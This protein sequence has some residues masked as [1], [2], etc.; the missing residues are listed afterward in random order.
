VTFETMSEFRTTGDGSFSLGSKTWPGL[1]KLVEECGEVLQVAG[2]LM[3]TAGAVGHWDGAGALDERMALEVCD[4]FAAAR[5]FF[6]LNGFDGNPV[7][8]EREHAKYMQFLKW[9]AKQVPLPEDKVTPVEDI[10]AL[11]LKYMS[12]HEVRIAWNREGDLCHVLK[13]YHGDDK[14]YPVCGLGIMYD[15]HTEAVDAAIAVSRKG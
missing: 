11:R 4:L 10:N 2:K 13:R 3:G 8:I 7:Y 12:D 5:A 9:H 15:S 14:W 6:Q 1:S